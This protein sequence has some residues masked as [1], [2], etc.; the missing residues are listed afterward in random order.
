M[1][2]GSEPATGASTNRQSRSPRGQLACRPGRSWV[3]QS[4]PLQEHYM[5]ARPHS[6]Q[7][8][9]AI[10]VRVCGEKQSV[11][12]MNAKVRRLEGGVEDACTQFRH[13]A[14]RRRTRPTRLIIIPCRTDTISSSCVP[15]GTLARQSGWQCMGTTCTCTWHVCVSGGKHGCGRTFGEGCESLTH[16]RAAS[17][18]TACTSAPWY[19]DGGSGDVGRAIGTWLPSPKTFNSRNDRYSIPSCP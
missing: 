4:E 10:V 17:D 12:L 5:W 14:S 6:R 7:R 15:V 9:G 2:L 1:A 3:M 8:E 18:E 19:M 11:L 16:H 13:L